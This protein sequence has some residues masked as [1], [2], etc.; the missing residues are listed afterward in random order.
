MCELAIITHKNVSRIFCALTNFDKFC[1]VDVLKPTPQ[2]EY[3]NTV[4]STVLN[5]LENE[6]IQP[7]KITWMF[8]K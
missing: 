1:Y 8:L 2:D 7:P 5:I 3:R 4:N 6:V